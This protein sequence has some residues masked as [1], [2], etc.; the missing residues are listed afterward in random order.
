MM[1][2]EEH[3]ALLERIKDPQLTDEARSEIDA[4]LWV[5]IMTP[6]AVPFLEQELS[7]L[8]QVFPMLA[9][10]PLR[11]WES[12]TKSELAMLQWEL[13]VYAY[14]ARTLEVWDTVKEVNPQETRAR[15]MEM[16]LRYP[17][18]DPFVTE[19]LDPL[20]LHQNLMR[21]LEECRKKHLWEEAQE[22]EAELPALEQRIQK[23]AAK[24]A[25]NH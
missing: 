21:R 9:K 15:M 6:E 16:S 17:W 24:T 18:S 1:T 3:K 13:Q 2:R 12:M 7:L 19:E 11:T 5:E 23:E 20:L 14:H 8:P 4:R 10:H 25:S 22:I